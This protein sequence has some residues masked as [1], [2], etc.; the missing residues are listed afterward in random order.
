VDFD[1]SQ[2]YTVQLRV[3][4]N[5]RQYWGHYYLYARM[6]DTTP[7][8]TQDGVILDFLITDSGDYSGTLKDYAGGELQSETSL[9]SGSTDLTVGWLAMEI[10]GDD[11]TVKYKD[12]IIASK[13]VSAHSGTRVGFGLQFCGSWAGGEQ[14]LGT[15]FFWVTGY[16][17]DP[18]SG[19]T[20]LRRT[21]FA[22]SANGTLYTEQTPGTLTAVT[23]DVGL[24]DDRVVLAAEANQRLFFADYSGIRVSGTD[25][26]VAGD[27]VTLTAEGVSD[28]TAHNIDVNNDVVVIT[29]GTGSVTDGTYKISSVATEALTIASSVGGS[30]NCT[31]RVQRAP[32]VYDAQANTLNIWTATGGEVPT[33]CPLICLYRDRLVLAGREGAPHEWYMSK[34]GDP[35]DFNYGGYTNEANR[36]IYGSNSDAGKVGDVVTALIPYSDDWLIF[37]CARSIWILRGDPAWGGTIDAV[38]FKTGI[39][40]KLAWTLVPG[41][42]VYFMGP[43]GIYRLAAGAAGLPEVVSLRKLPTRMRLVDPAETMTFMVYDATHQGIWVFQTPVSSADA[44][45]FYYDI[46]NDSWW[47]DKMDKDHGPVYAV[48]FQTRD[49]LTGRDG[50]VRRVNADASSDDGVAIDS[51]AYYT[52]VRLAGDAWREGVLLELDVAVGAGSD[53]VDISVHAGNTHREAVDASA[54][55]SHTVSGS[56]LR[57]RLRPYVRGGS[58]VLRAGNDSTYETWVLEGVYGTSVDAGRHR[59]P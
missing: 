26:A 35:Y 43:D 40:D 53:S 9:S 25:G 8:A 42:G 34:Q 36:P 45:H 11:I 27:G 50:Y 19:T 58:C 56:G 5:N 12:T 7:D 6:D 59:L 14:W 4:E 48:D 30:G 18:G 17:A 23:G 1:S 33:G 54:S 55:Y 16:N 32:K 49:S 47:L 21:L 15:D 28:W 22:A 20:V 3:I 44:T 41:G 39:I 37:G 57:P 13:T 38:T 46:R 24:I 52:P 10:D 51:Y 31:Y 29:S 2:A